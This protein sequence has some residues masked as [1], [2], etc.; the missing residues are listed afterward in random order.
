M[1]SEVGAFIEFVQEASL[2]VQS[3]VKPP[4]ESSVVGVAPARGH[5]APDAF[6]WKQWMG[7]KMKRLRTGYDVVGE[8]HAEPESVI[9]KLIDEMVTVA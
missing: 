5:G 9:P 8:V 4:S 3:G 6:S 1:L 2:A 7:P